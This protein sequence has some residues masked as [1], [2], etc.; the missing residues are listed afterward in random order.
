VAHLAGDGEGRKTMSTLTQAT[1]VQAVEQQGEFVP[2]EALLTVEQWANLPEVRPP[3][4]LLRGRLVQKI[5]TTND[6]D[7]ATNKLYRMYDEWADTSRWRFFSQGPG[8]EINKLSGYIPDVM[9]FPPSV[10]VQPRH[11]YNQRP[12]LVAEVLSKSTAH[13]DRTDKKQDYARIGVQLYLIVDTNARTI[14]VYRLQDGDYGEPEV[15]RDNDVWQPAELPGL[16][17][18]LSR[19]WF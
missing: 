8:V 18:E 10:S 9:G 13:L 12:F 2:V 19:L 3:Y 7:W 6:H 14:E 1:S 5:V 11:T 16:R 4:E 15:L 17:V